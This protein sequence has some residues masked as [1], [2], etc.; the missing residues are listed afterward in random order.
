MCP[1]C[2]SSV[3]IVVKPIQRSGMSLFLLKTMIEHQTDKLT[4]KQL[5]KNDYLNFSKE[6]V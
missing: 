4:P 1:Y 6:V 2:E 3:S 5:A